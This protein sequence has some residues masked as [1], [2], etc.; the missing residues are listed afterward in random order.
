M[1]L[2]EK[3][4]TKIIRK[5]KG[6]FLKGMLRRYV[7]G[8]PKSLAEVFL[9]DPRKLINNSPATSIIFFT[10]WKCGS[11]V[12]DRLLKELAKLLN[13]RAVDYQ[14]YL[15]YNVPNPHERLQNVNFLRT[16]FFRKGFFFG[17]LK[18]FIKIP[19]LENYKVIVQ[20]REPKDLLTS[21]Y[22]S[23]AYSHP[24]IHEAGRKIKK[25]FLESDINTMALKYGPQYFAHSFK[26]YMDLLQSNERFLFVKYEEMVT[27]F[28]SWLTKICVYLDVN[29]SDDERGRIYKLADFKVENENIYS[30]KRSVNPGNYRKHLSAGTIKELNKIFAETNAYFN[31]FDEP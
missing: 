19:S 27:N 7:Q 30:H 17:P 22:F 24:E 12:S 15:E 29:L 2:K 28:D 6:G 16:A 11:V 9:K 14:T 25:E 3:L 18:Y 13:L 23:F 1:K 26:P 10:S 5:L 20:L 4:V 31:Y 8:K 21:M